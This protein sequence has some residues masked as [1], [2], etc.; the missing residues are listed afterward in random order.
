MQSIPDDR[1]VAKEPFKF[2][3]VAVQTRVAAQG[4]Y[5]VTSVARDGLYAIEQ[6]SPRL[7]QREAC[8]CRDGN[9]LGD[10]I[11]G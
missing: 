3:V 2:R 6:C 9:R 11:D 10:W 1:F 7:D 8:L 4:T 5:K